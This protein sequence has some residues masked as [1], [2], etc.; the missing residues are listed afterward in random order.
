MKEFTPIMQL[1]NGLPIPHMWEVYTQDLQTVKYNRDGTIDITSLIEKSLAQC[2]GVYAWF[3][4]DL[5]VYI[6]KSE[7]K[8]ST[9]NGRNYSHQRSFIVETSKTESSGKKIRMFMEEN[10]LK[11][12]N[13]TVKFINMTDEHH[14]ISAFEK[15]SIEHFKPI[16]NT[17]YV[18]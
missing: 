1:L 16:F 17:H 18:K 14:F 11:S 10:K 15:I 12:L 7:G 4:D 6:G 9:V 5:L 13:M 3:I 8:T 2:H